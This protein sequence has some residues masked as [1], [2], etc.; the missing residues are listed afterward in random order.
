MLQG[1]HSA[2]LSTSIKLPLSITTLI[3]SILSGRLR[4]VLLYK[5]FSPN[6]RSILFHL[7]FYCV[8]ISRYECHILI[9]KLTFL[10]RSV[11]HLHRHSET[12]LQQCNLP[13]DPVLDKGLSKLQNTTQKFLISFKSKELQN[14]RS[15]L[16]QV[17]I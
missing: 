9:I 11:V 8:F 14:L 16:K 10:L 5:C 17:S 15:I 7:A 3:L 12:L 2:I 4:Q 13:L 1:E 6:G